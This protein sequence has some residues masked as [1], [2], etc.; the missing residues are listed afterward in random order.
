MTSLSRL[1]LLGLAL[2]LA[3]CS[4]TAEIL[5]LGRNPPDEF[6]VVERPPLSMP[7]E[8]ALRP[9]RPGAPRPQEVSMED[10]ARTTLL[11]GSDSSN[12]S[13]ASS[14][15]QELLASAHADKAD[16]SIRQTIDQEAS[17]KVVGSEHLVERLLWWHDEEGA[18]ATVDSFAESQRIKEAKAKGENVSTG[19]TPI[20]EKNK[21]S[22]LGL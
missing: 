18:A 14:V 22:W 4:D 16:P 2:A 15:E 10:K 17:Q 3:G 20:I 8:F 12:A 9:P 1:T 13:S 11:G 7:P 21:S 6:A 19:A 5:G